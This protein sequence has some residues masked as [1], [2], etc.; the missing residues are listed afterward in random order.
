MGVVQWYMGEQAQ[1][2]YNAVES[3]LSTAEAA[4]GPNYT[5]YNM[6]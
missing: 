2:Y 5:F 3:Y 1:S 6:H 4:F